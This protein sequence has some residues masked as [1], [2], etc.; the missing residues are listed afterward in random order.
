M[1]ADAPLRVLHADC[2]RCRALCCVG[3]A[4]AASS[5]FAFDKFAGDPCPNLAGDDR[6]SIHESL[7]EAGFPGCV[8]YDCYGA[9]QR[10]T[11]ERFPG[12]DWRTDGAVGEAMLEAFAALRP[13]HELLWHLAAALELPAAR[14]L[15]PALRAA[16]AEV[17]ALAGT[18]VGGTDITPAWQAATALLRET[19][20]RARRPYART[21]LLRDGAD[22][23]GADLRRVDL[24]GASLRG[25]Q[26][27]GADLRGA[28]LALADLTGADVRGADLRGADLR[29]ALFVT[30]PQLEA[31]EGDGRTR[32]PHGRRRPARWAPG[33]ASSR[34][35]A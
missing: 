15:W 34:A 21:A 27:L 9:G 25:A 4:F 14:A 35:G 26:M 11:Q 1:T 17:D 28:S 22:L 33:V 7:P 16:F 32:I 6:C 29:E 2:A 3:P 31:A 5:E 23:V 18:A 8:V 19:S 20:E 12:V 13:L 10:V 30:Q 24:R